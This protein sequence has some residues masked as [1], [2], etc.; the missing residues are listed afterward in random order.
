VAL[1]GRIRTTTKADAEGNTW[2]SNERSG[3]E[4][5]GGQFWERCPWVTFSPVILADFLTDD[6]N[7]QP[8]H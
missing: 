4:K 5:R 1:T 3:E 2:Y 8:N 7:Q 6:N